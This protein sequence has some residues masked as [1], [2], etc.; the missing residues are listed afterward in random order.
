M[1]RGASML[2]Q[3]TVYRNFT[4]IASKKKAF[5]TYLMFSEDLVQKVLFVRHSPPTG[6]CLLLLCFIAL[7][8]LTGL[9][10]TFLWFLDVPGFVARPRTVNV[11]TAVPQPLPQRAKVLH[12]VTPG[13]AMAL[14]DALLADVLSSD[15]FRAGFNV[16]LAPAWLAAPRFRPVASPDPRIRLPDFDVSLDGSSTCQPR[17]AVAAR[18]AASSPTP[19][20]TPRCATSRR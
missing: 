10:D 12:T 2:L 14:D 3:N 6:H 7:F 5:T 8:A 20:S 1:F 17:P 18:G 4:L 15:R 11:K 16:S 9:Y 19:A 13:I